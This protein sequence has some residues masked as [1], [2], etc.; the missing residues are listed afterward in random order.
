M[1]KFLDRHNVP[2]PNWVDGIALAVIG[3][4]VAMYFHK[5]NR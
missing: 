5:K 2:R 4:F 3:Y 1:Y